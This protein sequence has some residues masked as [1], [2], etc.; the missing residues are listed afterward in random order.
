MI[1]LAVFGLNQG[2]R[3]ARLIKDH[4]DAELAAVAGFGQQAEDVAAE[5]NAPLYADYN[6]LLANVELDGVA[7]ALPNS[8]HLPA[9]KACIDAG[10][11]FILL[12]KPIANTPEEGQQIID[13]CNEAGVTLLIGHHRRSSNL[14]L[15]LK[16]FLATGR[17]GKIVSIQSTFAIAKQLDYWDAEWHREPGGAVLLINAI[18]DI[19]DLNNVAGMTVKKVY[20]A[21][22]NFIR[23]Y[24]AE[25]SVTVLFEFAE[26]PTATY[27][28]SDGTPSPF[29]Y[30][31]LAH[32]NE[33]WSN[34]NYGQ[35]MVIY[36]TE[37]CFAFPAMDFF[38]YADKEHWGWRH[39]MVQEHFE[40][41]R[42]NPMESEVEHFID[43]CAGRETVPRCTG[44]QA[45][46]SLKTI[47]AV[48][49]SGNTGKVVEID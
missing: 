27:F 13:M 21:K 19:D 12:E 1:K 29:N 47:N 17:L 45:L 37:G 10:V 41:E 6:D 11:K 34:E 5:V 46:A 36:G 30:D 49:E 40:V 39:P 24:N 16:E 48:I 31:L 42:N 18:H 14:F 32:E 26:G 15:F 7:I 25:D 43:L 9:T 23:G 44:E 20:A 33:Q 38:T 28:V 8:L 3:I 4:D 2:A 22:R 35:S